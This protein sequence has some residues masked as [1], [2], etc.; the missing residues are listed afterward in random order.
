MRQIE[1]DG[2]RYEFVGSFN[3]LWLSHHEVVDIL[4]VDAGSLQLVQNLA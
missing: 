4:Q 3:K 2:K 1:A